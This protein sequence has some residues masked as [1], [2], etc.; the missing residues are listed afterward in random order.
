VEFWYGC[1][2]G[3]SAVG[4]LAMAATRF[5]TDS[6]IDRI[7]CGVGGVLIGYYAFHMLFLFEGGRYKLYY[8]AFVLPLYVGYRLIRGFLRRDADRAQRAKY[9]E[10]TAAAEEWRSTRR[11]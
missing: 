11:W 4:L 2:L 5:G 9:A 7:L 3:L 1:L 6:V 8:F 10:A